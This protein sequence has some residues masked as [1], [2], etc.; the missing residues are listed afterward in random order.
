MSNE[1]TRS[2]LCSDVDTVSLPRHSKSAIY[3][4]EQL[5]PDSDDSLATQNSTI[6]SPAYAIREATIARSTEERT[7]TYNN[8][9][10]NSRRRKNHDGR[11]GKLTLVRLQKMRE[12]AA[13]INTTMVKSDKD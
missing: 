11:G 9:S 10:C 3:T 1:R 7:I 4:S 13:N 5:P 6:P 8:L 12:I 2:V